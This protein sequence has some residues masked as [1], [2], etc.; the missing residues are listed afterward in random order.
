MCPYRRGKP[1]IFQSIAKYYAADEYGKKIRTNTDSAGEEPDGAFFMAAPRKSGGADARKWS[2]I[3]VQ[4]R[5]GK[6][7][8]EAGEFGLLAPAPNL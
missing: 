8:L 3:S 6:Q 5:L 1:A 7:R 2:V 4:R